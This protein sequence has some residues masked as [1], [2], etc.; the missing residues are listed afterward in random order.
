LSVPRQQAGRQIAPN[1]ILDNFFFVQR[2]YLNGN[3]FVYRSDEPVLID[4]AYAVDFHETERLIKG[5]GVSVSQVRLIINTHCHCDHVGGNKPIQDRSSC[6]VAMHKIG[7]YFIDTRDDWATWWRYFNQ[8]ADFFRCTSALEDGNT[9]SVGP[10][11][12]KVI[13]TPGHAADGIVLYHAD[14][15]I[16]ISS[17]TLWENDM[18]ALTVRIEGSRACFSMLES[19]DKLEQLDVKIA[20]PGHGRPFTDVT[21]A[22]DRTRARLRGF[23]KDRNRIGEDLIKKIIIYTLM[24]RKRVDANTFFK[25]L[26]SAV[27]FRET[28]DLYAGGEY[29]VTYERIMKDFLRRGIVRANDGQLYTTVKP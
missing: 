12:F 10:H 3:H 27:W 8:E 16:L 24:M 6:D 28:V 21:D 22:I 15:K 26:M 13:Y 9:I 2:G 29:S 7:K 1:E 23:L 14:E 17:D 18:A 19:M 20:Y 5:L 4:T 25:D 11:R